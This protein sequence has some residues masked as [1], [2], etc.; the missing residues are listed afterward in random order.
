MGVSAEVTTGLDPTGELSL[1]RGVRAATTAMTDDFVRFVAGDVAWLLIVGGA[2]IGGR[3]FVPAYALLCL[4]VAVSFGVCRMATFAVRGS[5]PRLSQLWAGVTRRGWAGFG[6]GCIQMV[7]LAVVAT[8]I[9]IA[10]EAPSVPL[11]LSAVV[12]GYAG[13]FLAATVLSIWPLL[14]DPG[15]EQLPIR[16]IV[17][18]GLVLIAARPGRYLALVI[19][20]ALLVAVGLQTFIAALVLPALGLLLAC[21]VALP[22]A[23]ELTNPSGCVSSRA[24][25]GRPR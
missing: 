23:D 22:L 15:R 2:L 14:L 1:W 5:P 9:V 8:N 12:S 4:V 17:R 10:I 7:L 18:L 25:N 13:L 20:E 11:V 19:V 16:R 21:W 3:L 24:P 6:L